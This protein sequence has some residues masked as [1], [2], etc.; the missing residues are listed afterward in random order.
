M[1]EKARELTKE[2]KDNINILHSSYANISEI[3]KEQ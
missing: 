2:Y 1:I 3:T